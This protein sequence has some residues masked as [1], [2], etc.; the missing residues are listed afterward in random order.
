MPNVATYL[1]RIDPRN[2]PE[3]D[4][5]VTTEEVDEPAPGP[6]MPYQTREGV[7]MA[8]RDR[9]LLGRTA[10]YAGTEHPTAE[11]PLAG[12]RRTAGS[13]KRSTGYD[14]PPHHTDKRAG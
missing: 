1:T 11:R 8:P 4:F 10:L 3:R 14:D 9:H 6:I 7:E 2:I 12:A 13:G 5:E